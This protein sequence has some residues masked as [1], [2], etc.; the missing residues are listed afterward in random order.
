MPRW[1]LPITVYIFINCFDG[2]RLSP[3]EALGIVV[4]EQDA[5]AGAK[6]IRGISNAGRWSFASVT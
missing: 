6:K 5:E 3:A 2:R 4:T 1:E